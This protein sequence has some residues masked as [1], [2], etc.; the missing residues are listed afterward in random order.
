MKVVIQHVS[1]PKYRLIITLEP[2]VEGTAVFWAE[3]F[4]SSEVA[5]RIEPIVVSANEQN[6]ERP[7][8][9]VLEQ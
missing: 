6:L 9:E 4:E 1:E 2:P 7:S 8:A 3:V 5:R